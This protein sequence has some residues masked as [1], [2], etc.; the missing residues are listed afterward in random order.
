[1]PA[2]AGRGKNVRAMVEQSSSLALR[3]CARWTR[4]GVRS[5]ARGPAHPMDGPRPRSRARRTFLNGESTGTRTGVLACSHAPVHARC[6]AR[7]CAHSVCLLLRSPS[8]RYLEPWSVP[9][10]PRRSCE[11]RCR[12]HVHGCKLR[13]AC[14][15][16]PH[17][18]R[19]DSRS[20]PRYRVI[21][22][23]VFRLVLGCTVESD[24]HL[25]CFGYPKPHIFHVV[26]V[27]SYAAL[28]QNSPNRALR[29]RCVPCCE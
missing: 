22:R 12:W 6:L 29:P 15:A 26:W 1:M 25:R 28:A 9:G 23:N 27:K 5:A 20:C 13:T 24:T 8:A 10:C 21:A 11:R 4:E 17:E 19:S 16:R 14:S 18:L 7:S 3:L 2:C